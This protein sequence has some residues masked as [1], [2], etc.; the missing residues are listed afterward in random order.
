MPHGRLKTCRVFL[1][2]YQRHTAAKRETARITLG[3]RHAWLSYTNYVLERL[4]FVH[5][6]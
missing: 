5:P 6:N 4:S 1:R 2:G 3:S